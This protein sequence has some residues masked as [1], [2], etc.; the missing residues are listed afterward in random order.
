MYKLYYNTLGREDKYQKSF[1][2]E[3]LTENIGVQD[4]ELEFEKLK[5]IEG[6]ENAI[7]ELMNL[8]TK[9]A[10]ILRG[11]KSSVRVSFISK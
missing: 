8:K 10:E 9:R 1:S 4:D 5:S 3:V 11:S 2:R 7:D 6:L